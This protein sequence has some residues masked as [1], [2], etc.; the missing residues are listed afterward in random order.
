MYSPARRALG[1]RRSPLRLARA[2]APDCGFPLGCYRAAGEAPKSQDVVARGYA[3][4]EVKRPGVSAALNPA[5]RERYSVA[6][7]RYADGFD[8]VLVGLS[9][10]HPAEMSLHRVLD[11]RQNAYAMNITPLLEGILHVA[12]D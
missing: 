10:P 7:A 5:R 3:H 1:S 4:I 11:A 9:A 8:H 2:A 6:H 12:R